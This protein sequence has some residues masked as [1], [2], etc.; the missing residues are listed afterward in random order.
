M[1]KAKERI[2]PIAFERVDQN[3]EVKNQQSPSVK[4]SVPKP[5]QTQRSNISQRSSSL[6]R[7]STQESDT[8]TVTSGEPIK[9]SAREYIIPIA[10]EGGGYVTPRAGSLEPSESTNSASRMKTSFVKPKRFK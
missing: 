6:S 3:K 4:P 5:F 7:Q 10:I 1:S 2:I 9:K 8:D